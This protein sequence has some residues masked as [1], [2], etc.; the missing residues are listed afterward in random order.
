LQ[1]PGKG[2]AGAV[3]DRHGHVVVVDLI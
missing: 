3:R 1:G 2:R